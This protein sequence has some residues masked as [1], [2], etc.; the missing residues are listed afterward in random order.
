EALAKMRLPVIANEGNYLIV[1]LPGSDTLA[2]RKLM[3]EGVMIRPMTGF[4]YPNHIRV[5]L[6]GMEAMESFVGALK[7]ILN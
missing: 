6:A 5:T 4:R 1:K 7:K 2:Y 3:R